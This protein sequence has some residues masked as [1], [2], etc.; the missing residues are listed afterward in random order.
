MR[1]WLVIL[2]STCA[3]A[4]LD[5]TLSLKS[6]CK[7]DEITFKCVKYL[8]AYDGDTITVEIPAVHPIIG[9]QISVRILGIDTPE[10]KGHGACERQKAREAQELVQKTLAS[11]KQIDLVNIQRDK[12]FRLLADV[13]VDGKLLK[14][15]ILGAHLAYEYQGKTKPK[16]NW[17]EFGKKRVPASGIQE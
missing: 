4:D 14:D 17:C 8:K 11:A 13:Q 2:F 1:Y 16:I 7:H 15:I 3:L 9:R 12:Y 10:M 5:E 6:N